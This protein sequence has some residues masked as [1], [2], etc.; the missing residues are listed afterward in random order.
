MKDSI[1][2]CLKEYYQNVTSVVTDNA[3]NMKKK[4]KMHL[5]QK[6][7]LTYGWCKGEQDDM[8]I[9]LE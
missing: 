6:D 5:E 7:I 4:I 2:K 3:S 8:K 1:R 9:L